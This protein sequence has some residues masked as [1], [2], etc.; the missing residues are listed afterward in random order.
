MAAGA[1]RSSERPAMMALPSAHDSMVRFLRRPAVLARLTLAPCVSLLLLA[2]CGD[3][4]AGPEGPARIDVTL[5][6]DVM[7]AKPGERVIVT[8]TAAPRN[9]ARVTELELAPLGIVAGDRSVFVGDDP[10]R[11]AVAAKDTFWMPA[12]VGTAKFVGIARGTNGVA[13]ESDTLRV[14]VADAAPPVIDSVRLTH[15]DGVNQGDSVS[16]VIG[17]HDDAILTQ[18]IVRWTGA[19]QQSDTTRFASSSVPRHVVGLRLPADADVRAPLGVTV[20]AIDAGGNE[21]TSALT[22][23]R[24][25][26]V[27]P[28]AIVPFAL[29]CPPGVATPC[30]PGDTVRFTITA[31][32]DH[33]LSWIGYRLGAP[34]S[35]A[36]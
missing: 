12:A 11:T 18:V 3:E 20:T 7:I 19:V 24:V 30:I 28:P 33:E 15:P 23:I 1:F 27:T 32:D 9:G 31:S 22:E 4:S 16:V 5:T 17:A 14:T 10:S 35:R 21:T 29:P 25:R 8:L 2:G 34:A 26:D 36:D 13:G 6:A